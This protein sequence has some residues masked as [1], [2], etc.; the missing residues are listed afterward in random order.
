MPQYSRVEHPDQSGL[1]YIINHIFC[2]LKLP[3]ANDHSLEN[4]IALSQAVVDAAFAF[5]DQLP[6][7]QQLLWT[8]SLKM[9]RNFK[10]SI[11]FST[12]SAKEVEHQ[13]SAMHNEGPLFSSS[14]LFFV[15]TI[16][17]QM[18]WYI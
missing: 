10:D 9:F 6:S 8:R 12:L 15:L 5:N 4:D 2:P 7:S 18:Y 17:L 1:E 13:I 11:R 16:Y 14:L 3:Q